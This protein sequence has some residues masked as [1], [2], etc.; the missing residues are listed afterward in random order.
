M[1]N[2]GPRL[3]KLYKFP[4]NG[5]C[6]WVSDFLYTSFASQ[7]EINTFIKEKSTARKSVL[8]KFLELDIFD[9]LYKNSRE[10]YIVLKNKLKQFDSETNFQTSI[11]V[12]KEHLLVMED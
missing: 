9:T 5:D 3:T 4:T 8:S 2:F 10:D 11:E 1:G 7:G 6:E 12:L